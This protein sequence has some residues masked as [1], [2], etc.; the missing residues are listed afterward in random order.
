MYI[1][2]SN[3]QFSFT[4]TCVLP[5]KTYE[6]DVV[7]VLDF[8]KNLFS[9]YFNNV[10]QFPLKVVNV[11][12]H[13]AYPMTVYEEQTIFLSVSPYD[14]NGNPG[15]YWSQ[16]IYQFSHE[17]CHYMNYGHTV[18]SMR[19]FE[20]T[21]CELASHFFL[22]KSAEE[23]KVNPPFSGC[24]NYS[25]SLLVYEL[26]ARN[27]IAQFNLNKLSDINSAHLFSLQEDE[28]QRPKNRYMALQLLPLFEANPSL[29]KIVPE[30]VNL[31]VSN[32]F[33][34]N[35]FELENKSKENISCIKKLFGFEP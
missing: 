35:F 7:T 6:R 22:L 17:F 27:D 23:W 19:W 12:P 31:P 21:L 28:Y 30:L 32:S 1:F 15:C 33:A 29:W 16:F 26:N 18:Q 5:Y 13:K 24:N 10:N 14:S 11:Y 3:P 34:Q 8:V 9:K 2:P 25:H 20:E 4:E